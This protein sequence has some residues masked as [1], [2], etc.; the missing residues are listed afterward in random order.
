ME[1]SIKGLYEEGHR[2]GFVESCRKGN[3][4]SLRFLFYFIIYKMK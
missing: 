3:A 2:R 1:M 4:W